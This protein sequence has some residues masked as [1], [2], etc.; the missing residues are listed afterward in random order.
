MVQVSSEQDRLT[1][2]LHVPMSWK[3]IGSVRVDSDGFI[4]LV[5]IK[6]HFPHYNP[7]HTNL[8]AVTFYLKECEK[9]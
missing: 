8:T 7:F 9:L 6:L 3:L 1:G 2:I 5:D 4:K